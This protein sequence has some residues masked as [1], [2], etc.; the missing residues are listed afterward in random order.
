MENKG[1]AAVAARGLRAV[2]GKAQAPPPDPRDP[3]QWVY[4]ENDRVKLGVKIASGA[5][6]GYLSAQGS[7]RN[8]LNHF[9]Q[10]R[11]VQQSYYG[12]PDG[13]VWGKQPWRYN[14][15]QGGEYRGQPSTLVQVRPARHALYAKTTPRNWAG[16]QLLPEVTMEEWI[17]LAGD[18]VHV[19]YKMTY[20]GARVHA[21]TTQEVPAVFT[22]PDLSTLVTYE[23]AE[24][25]QMRP[26]VRKT[27]GWPNQSQALPEHWAAYVDKTDF[28]VGV[29]VP[30]AT[31]ATCYRYVAD[32]KSDCSYIAPL[33]TFA[34]TPG[35]VWQYDLYLTVG[36]S[37]AIRARFY[38]LNRKRAKR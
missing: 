38:A 7:D 27:P 30:V 8:L 14:P 28:G 15:V 34:L 20:R 24:P 18:L 1:I 11:F 23:G 26:T 5:C 33:T 19:R 35:K 32:G 25:F 36:S 31:E 21:P 17:D 10:G 6:I 16:G 12:D 2:A 22:A 4:L 3:K 37:D 13:S 9:D 29:Y